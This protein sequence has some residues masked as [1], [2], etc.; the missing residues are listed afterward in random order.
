MTSSEPSEG[1]IHPTTIE[2]VGYA[3]SGHLSVRTDTNPN[4]TLD[5]PIDQDHSWVASSAEVSVWNL[6]QLYVINGTF[7]EGSPG[8]NINPNG[9][10]GDYPNGWSAGSINTDPD[11]QQ[12][13][14]Y[15]DTGRSYVTMQNEAEVT[16]NP[17]HIYTHWAGTQVLWNQSVD[18]TPYTDQ[19]V[20]SFDYLYLQ[21][22]LGTGYS[23]NCSIHVFINGTSLWQ[24]NLPTLNQRGIWYST[25]QVP[26]NIALLGN[27]TTFMIGL[28]IDE[29]MVVDGDDDYDGDSFPDGAIN[30]QFISVYL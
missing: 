20:L 6:T 19:F 22:P 4:P 23:G 17:Q 12:I 30:T 28:V 13:A 3:T 9:T 27:S 26:I 10:L 16:N 15:D 7:E 11:Q 1:V 8:I 14:A 29:T 18:V 24:V 5:L 21:G 2:N 25:G